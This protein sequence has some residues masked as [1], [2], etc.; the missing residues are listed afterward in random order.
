[1]EGLGPD[2][3]SLQIQTSGV[4]MSVL[5]GYLAVVCV[6][7]RRL[8][9]LPGGSVLT[10]GAGWLAAGLDHSELWLHSRQR[11]ASDFGQSGAKVVLCKV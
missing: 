10:L 2:K 9:C 1:M 6:L 7:S 3:L 8:M 5:L 11:A 4:E